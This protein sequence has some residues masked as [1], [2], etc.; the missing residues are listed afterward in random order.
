MKKK[1]VVKEDIELLKPG[2]DELNIEVR[3]ED[4]TIWL[5]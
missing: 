4:E 2:Q 3:V 1:Y 5:T